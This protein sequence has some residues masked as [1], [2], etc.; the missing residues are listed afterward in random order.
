M[1]TIEEFE[2]SRIASVL[3]GLL[4]TVN[5]VKSWYHRYMAYRQR[6]ADAVL[7]FYI[8]DHADVERYLDKV[9]HNNLYFMK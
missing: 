5:S 2:T 4:I 8:K 1:R 3:E 9:K 6:Q 7:A